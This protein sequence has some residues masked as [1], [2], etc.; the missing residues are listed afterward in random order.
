MIQWMHALSK[1][2]VATLLM[3]VL[4]LSFVVWGIA[5]VF[6][7]VSATGV[8]TVGGTDISAQ[9]FERSYRNFLRNQGQQMGTEITPD[10][11]QK[12]GLS[13]IALQQMISRTAMN[14]E[15]EQ[16]GLTTSL[17]AVRQNVRAMAPFRGT[18]GQFDRPTFNQA[19]QNAGYT[20]DQF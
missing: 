16:L 1:S 4:T 5:D 17:E 12:M 14:N 8:A 20:E 6:I 9:E 2:W 11:A 18:L 10:M 7:G 15:A 13:Q 19:I 3:G